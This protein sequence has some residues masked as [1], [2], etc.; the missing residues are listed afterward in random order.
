M[1]LL[2]PESWQLSF[3]KLLGTRAE[4]EVSASSIRVAAVS[5]DMSRGLLL[6]CQL[7]MLKFEQSQP[8]APSAGEWPE[9]RSKSAKCWLGSQGSCL[10]AVSTA[11]PSASWL[12]GT[13][14]GQIPS[15]GGE[16]REDDCLL[17]LAFPFEVLGFQAL[18][19][20]SDT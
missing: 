19:S 1:P 4:S 12:G 10:L 5:R 15:Q 6:F 11:W 16:A 13:L 9:D 8:L 17:P 3:Q 18:T 14:K 2:F 7:C 20:G